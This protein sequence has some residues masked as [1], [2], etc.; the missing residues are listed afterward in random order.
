DVGTAAQTMLL[1]AHSL[2]LG[3]GVVTSFSQAAASAVLNLPEGWS[4]EMLV[5]LG[6]AAPLQPAGMRPR[7]KGTRRGV[8]REGRVPGPDRPPGLPGSDSRHVGPF[9]E[10]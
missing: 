7:G 9:R 6:H 4:P 8:T 5:C 3:S 2:G 10:V 1:A